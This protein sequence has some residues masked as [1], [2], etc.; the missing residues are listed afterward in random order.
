MMEHIG[1]EQLAL[2]ATGDLAPKETSAVAAH[3]QDCETCR[4]AVAGF[5][6]TQGFVVSALVDP[7]V[8]ELV[9]VRERVSARLQQT[10]G[11]HW[12]WAWPALGAAAAAA[13]VTTF[14][15]VEQKPAVMPKPA[16]PVAPLALPEVPHLKIPRLQTAVLHVGHVRHREAGIRSVDLIARADQPA[17][18]K[19][20][21]ADPNVVIL[22]QSNGGVKGE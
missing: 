18:I 16:P 13:L 21:T 11:R 17:L 9:A 10:G 19:M 8:E 22:W 6:E 2:Y 14:I 12:R 1:E 4:E 15:T 5:R 7:A 20:T 3:V